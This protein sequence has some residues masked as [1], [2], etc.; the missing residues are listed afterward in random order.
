MNKWKTISTKAVHS[1]PWI[2]VVEDECEAESG[3]LTYTYSRRIDQGP[4]IIAEQDE[5]LW[6]VKQYRH[7]IHK[8]IW[9][10]P[11]EGMHPGETWEQAACRG[12]E[13]E[14]VFKVGKLLFLSDLYPDPGGLQQQSKVFVAT[15]LS[16]LREASRLDQH[17]QIEKGLFSLEE[18]DQLIV[19]GEICD[20]WT[21]SGLFLYKRYLGR[22]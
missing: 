12:V 4:V 20:G 15:E 17:E 3:T 19:R 10:F 2:E 18:I 5:K 7:P 8:I 11:A 1:T 14:L 21:F 16:K 22:I 13:E 9:Q 6:M